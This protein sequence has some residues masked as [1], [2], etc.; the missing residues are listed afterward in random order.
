MQSF[1]ERLD[2]GTRGIPGVPM[3]RTVVYDGEA[4]TVL[5]LT[6][7]KGVHWDVVAVFTD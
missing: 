6:V 4:P 7:P 1:V 5:E 2:D 3:V